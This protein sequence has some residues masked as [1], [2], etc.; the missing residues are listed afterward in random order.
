MGELEA[1]ALI[2]ECRSYTV[3]YLCFIFFRTLLKVN[4]VIVHILKKTG[5]LSGGKCISYGPIKIGKE[6]ITYGWRNARSN[7]DSLLL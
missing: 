3:D 1:L 2:D 7:G 5:Y 4:L 6:D